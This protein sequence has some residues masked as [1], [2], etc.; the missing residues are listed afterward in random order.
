[1]PA[2]GIT[3]GIATGKSAFTL[4]LRELLPDA[5]FFDADQ[6]AR[7]L[8]DHDPEA[9]ALIADTFGGAIYSAGGDLKR[10]EL[11]AIVFA[12]PGKKQALEQILH[13]RI[14]RQWATEAESR[15][16]STELFLADIPLLYETGGEALCDRV[17]VV[18]CSPRAQ[19]ERLMARS[20]LDRAA[21]EQMIAAQMPLNAKIARADH[22]AWNN[23]P[24]SLL[25]SQAETL[26]GSWRDSR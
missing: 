7:D 21:A 26:A 15:R 5:L 24:R 12:D 6:A 4:L 10:E 22:L 16:Q 19:L 14:R 8:T 3:G 13:P 25:R 20:S 18:A 17:V 11:R 9:R 2:I 23:G 1:M